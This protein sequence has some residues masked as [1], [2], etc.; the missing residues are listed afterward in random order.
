MRMGRGRKVTSRKFDF[1]SFF[2]KVE[3]SGRKSSP[4]A[5]EGTKIERKRSFSS[6]DPFQSK[7]KRQNKQHE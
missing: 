3:S 1:V 6:K 4:D 7:D 2:A 5:V